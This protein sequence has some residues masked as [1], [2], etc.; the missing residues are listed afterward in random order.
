MQLRWVYLE[1]LLIMW[2]QNKVRRKLFYLMPPIVRSKR[3]LSL[4]SVP[5]NP[6][7]T[8]TCSTTITTCLEGHLGA[9]RTICFLTVNSL[10][11]VQNPSPP[12]ICLVGPILQLKPMFSWESL[13]NSLRRWNRSKRLRVICLTKIT[14]MQKSQT[15]HKNWWM[16][17]GIL[18]K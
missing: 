14:F 5:R 3:C 13:F 17:E 9:L 6:R 2:V 10:F 18:Y 12:K 11:S 16:L 15:K 7:T 1:R 4:R 8:Q